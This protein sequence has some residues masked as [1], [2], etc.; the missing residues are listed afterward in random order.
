MA[1]ERETDELEKVSPNM[2]WSIPKFTEYLRGCGWRLSGR[3]SELVERLVL[4]D[5]CGNDHAARL[6]SSIAACLIFFSVVYATF[7]YLLF[8]IG[9]CFIART[10]MQPWQNRQD[11]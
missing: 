7:L 11:Q 9:H 6:R 4:Y 1:K 10:L 3:K 2:F 8:N 5:T